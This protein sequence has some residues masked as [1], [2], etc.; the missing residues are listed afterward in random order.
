MTGKQII[1]ARVSELQACGLKARIGLPE[2]TRKG[3]SR[4]PKDSTDALA[5]GLS[6][7]IQKINTRRSDYHFLDF[8]RHA[9]DIAWTTCIMIS[10]INIIYY[11]IAKITQRV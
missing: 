4:T 6:G 7:V 3:E 1:R 10:L 5:Y 2:E 8:L 11:S 9:P